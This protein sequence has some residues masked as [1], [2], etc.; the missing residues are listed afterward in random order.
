MARDNVTR[1]AGEL[2]RVLY[3]IALDPSRKFGSLE[4][5]I[6]RLAVAFRRRGSLL[7]PRFI[8]APDSG[9]AIGFAEAGVEAH[10][11]DLSRF[12][13]RTLRRL[14]DL[15]S[16]HR[17]QIAHWGIV[18][19]VHLFHQGAVGVATANRAPAPCATTRWWM[20]RPTASSR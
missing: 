17:L 15:I 11:L 10:C 13:F 16:R 2:R 1:A 3:A 4:E 20:S 7:V 5:Q 6:S 18:S 8:T 19:P 9:R 14:L 12:D